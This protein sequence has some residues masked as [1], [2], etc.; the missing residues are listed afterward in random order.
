MNI[1]NPG[2]DGIRITNINGFALNRSNWTTAPARPPRTRPSTSATSSTGTPVNGTINITNNVIGPAAGNSP[3]DSL[4]VGI[5]SGTSTWAVTN[6]TFRRTGNSGI[7]LELRGT[8]V[9]TAFNVS[10]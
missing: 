1:T 3:H 4:A 10:N 5:G 8:A 9:V 7:N 6:T 2:T